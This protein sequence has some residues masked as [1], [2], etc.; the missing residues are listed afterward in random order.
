MP[1]QSTPPY[2]WH[3]VDAPATTADAATYHRQRTAAAIKA[4]KVPCGRLALADP[5]EPVLL[6]YF[7]VETTGLDIQVEAITQCSVACVLATVGQ[8]GDGP[9]VVSQS[10][11]RHTAYVHTTRPVSAKITALTGIT[12]AD[13][14]VVNK[15]D[16]AP[17]VGA[18]LDVMRRDARKM[19]GAG[20][21]VF[22]VK[23]GDGLDAIIGEIFAAQRRALAA[24]AE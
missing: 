13:V 17:A 14:L 9:P 3:T 5:T 15:V 2:Q 10:L 6:L 18:D 4:H 16:L 22:A 23:H 19:R 12:Q 7:D 11:A 20:P 24:A 21:T 8:G 1:A